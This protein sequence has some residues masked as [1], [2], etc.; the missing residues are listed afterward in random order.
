MKTLLKQLAVLI[1]AS[2]F[3]FFPIVAACSA[4][5]QHA[6]RTVVDVASEACRFTFGEHPEELP[7]GV[8]L[9]DF[10]DQV[11][12]YQPFVDSIL[13]THR[14]LSARHGTPGSH[15]SDAGSH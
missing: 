12:N 8:S 3:V 1:V 6:I 15:E 4:A 14:V 10:C 11:Q 13:S 9:K 2:A 7:P 5:Q